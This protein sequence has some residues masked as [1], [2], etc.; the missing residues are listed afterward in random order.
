AIVGAMLFF[1]FRYR[2][3]TNTEITPRIYGNH[4][5]EIIWTVIP[6]VVVVVIG[7]GGIVLRERM[8]EV[9]DNFLPIYVTAWKWAWE[10]KYSSGKKTS[11]KNAELVVPVNQ[12]VKLI[13]TSKDVI[14]SLFIPAVRIKQDA[15]PGQL[16]YMTFTATKTGEY[17]IFCTEYC[18]TEHSMMLAKLKVVSEEEFK[19]WVNTIPELGLPP[20]LLGQKLYVQSGCNTC[21]SLRPGERKV[22]PSF[23]DVFGNQRVFNDGTS[24]IGDENYIQESILYPNKR[25]VKGFYE[26]QM[27]SYLGQFTQA[28]LQALVTFISGLRNAPAEELIN[29]EVEKVKQVIL[30][31]LQPVE[32]GKLVY[33]QRGCE[34]CHS[35]DGSIRVGP[36]FKGLF[37][38]ERNFEDGSKA[39]ADEQYL[40]ES[41]LKP[42]LKIVKGYPPAMQSYEGIVT[43]SELE[44]L[45]AFIK[46]IK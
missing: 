44:G 42:A 39:V 27:P 25:V 40:K 46:D 32:R 1:A 8:F 12:P 3:K 29:V 11:G 22:G 19:S 36:S 30:D 24:L 28:E 37:G 17:P 2:S 38:S 15:V 31:E 16:K 10:F 6:T 21:H 20:F 13:I 23:Y 9:K 5:L 45:I 34:G 35:L 14:H 4:M 7:W 18:G 26:N 43:E 41:I 33:K